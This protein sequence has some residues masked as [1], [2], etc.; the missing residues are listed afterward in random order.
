MHHDAQSNGLVQV[1]KGIVDQA[2]DAGIPMRILGACAFRIHCKNFNHLFEDLARPITDIDFVS[3]RNYS[4]KVLDFF[5]KLGY[6]PNQRVIGFY[7]RRRHIYYAPNNSLQIDVFMDGLEMC[8]TVDLRSRLLIDRP[9]IPL[10][11]LLLEKLQ[12]VK[13]NEKDLKDMMV[14]LRE[15]E[16]SNSEGEAINSSYIA[17]LLT[18]D[19]GFYYTSM[20][21]LDK[22]KSYANS[23]SKLSE[24]DRAD[25]LDKVSTLQTS[26][27]NTQKS[28]K[29]KLRAKIG[30]SKIWYHEIEDLHG[31]SVQA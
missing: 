9:T 26:L 25:V 8:H 31:N 11:D 29:W 20:M 2:E 17:K 22:L 21:N 5:Q 14:L 24:P 28:I 6:V 4:N 7:G 23:F 15:H 18:D 10:A 12:I 3:L 1:A 19:W 30:T 27:Q 16:V 13:I